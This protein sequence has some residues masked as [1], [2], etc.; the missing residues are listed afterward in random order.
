MCTFCDTTLNCLQV[1]QF[2]FRQEQL[3]HL[4]PSELIETAYLSALLEQHQSS[5]QHQCFS[6]RFSVLR[7]FLEQVVTIVPLESLL[8]SIVYSE[9]KT[10]LQCCDALQSCQLEIPPSVTMLRGLHEASLRL[11]FEDSSGLDA[12][13]LSAENDEKIYTTAIAIHKSQHIIPTAKDLKSA[14]KEA[15][16]SY[17]QH[18]SKSTKPV[19]KAHSTPTISEV[20]E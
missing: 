9:K 18:I 5:N 19:E 8:Y 15:H 17:R 2:T 11:F 6:S 13:G 1:Y 20:V 3:A 10:A 14:R 7:D 4:T 16:K 12:Q